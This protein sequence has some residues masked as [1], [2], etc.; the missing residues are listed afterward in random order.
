MVEDHCGYPS[1]CNATFVVWYRVL[2]SQLTSFILQ[3]II[4]S[5]LDGDVYMRFTFYF[6]F[7]QHEV[8]L[9]ILNQLV[10]STLCK[11]VYELV[12]FIKKNKFG[13]YSF[14]SYE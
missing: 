3:L 10:S 8:N 14:L 4:F 7:V 5:F 2:V 6:F 13:S 12:K 1:L 9:T 11:I